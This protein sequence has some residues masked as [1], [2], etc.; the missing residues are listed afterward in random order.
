MG[1]VQ[2]VRGADRLALVAVACL[3]VF[4]VLQVWTMAAMF[5]ARKDIVVAR[6]IQDECSGDTVLEGDTARWHLWRTFA[7]R[8]APA[9]AAWAGACVLLAMCAGW[10]VYVWTGQPT[11]S[12]AVSY[13]AATPRGRTV[14]YFALAL[15]ALAVAN[16]AL[17]EQH[18][19]RLA[20]AV[21]PIAREY[22]DLIKRLQTTCSAAKAA[23]FKTCFGALSPFYQKELVQ[24]FFMVHPGDKSSE[25]VVHATLNKAMTN[26]NDMAF[27]ALIN[28]YMDRKWAQVASEQLP[29]L[30]GLFRALERLKDKSRFDPEPD[31]RAANR[32]L[33]KGVWVVAILA[34]ALFGL[35]PLLVDAVGVD[36]YGWRAS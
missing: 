36:L 6:H 8:S 5:N 1:I 13:S 14:T 9:P 30:A 26:S 32:A 28:P 24:R 19:R 16:A 2:F 29:S 34:V 4:V 12:A 20:V 7:D 10:V 15:A 3:L 23:G 18:Q 11:Q 33:E 17:L 27:L 25:D 31:M 35:A 22:T 21:A